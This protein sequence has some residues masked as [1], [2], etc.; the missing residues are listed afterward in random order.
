MAQKKNEPV[1]HELKLP[2]QGEFLGTVIKGLG[3]LNF[4][5]ACSDGKERLCTIPGR[6][7]RRFWIKEG[8]VVIIKP[9]VVQSDEK[10][11]VLW[12]YSIMDKDR[13]KQKGYK[14]PS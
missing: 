4:T 9:W 12:R 13:L 14:L 6:F 7:K 11:D 8:D 3:A 10:G 1:S 2:K 5:I